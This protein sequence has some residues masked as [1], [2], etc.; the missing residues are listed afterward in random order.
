MYPTKC[1]KR[2]GKDFTS[3]GKNLLDSVWAAAAQQWI[4][5]MEGTAW[6]LLNDHLSHGHPT[7]YQIS[8]C[9]PFPTKHTSSSCPQGR[10][11]LSLP[12]S[13]SPSV[14]LLPGAW[15]CH[16]RPWEWAHEVRIKMEAGRSLVS[17]RFMEERLHTSSRLNS[18]R[19]ELCIWQE[20]RLMSCREE[21]K[22]LLAEK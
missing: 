9:T 2:L 13:L 21:T 11:H 22:N 6:I 4:H 10:P 16:L 1:K 15:S 19:I 5:T 8:T 3:L 14:V 20:I 18:F 7:G 17:E 12:P